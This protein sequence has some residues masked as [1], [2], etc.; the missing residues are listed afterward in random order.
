[1]TTETFASREEALAA[2]K[3]AIKTEK[4]VWNFA[5]TRDK[6]GMKRRARLMLYFLRC[7]GREAS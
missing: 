6:E 5:W 1:M 4:P 2:E 3:V 7:A